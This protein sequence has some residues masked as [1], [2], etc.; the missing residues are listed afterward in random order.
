MSQIAKQR[1]AIKKQISWSLTGQR[2]QKMKSPDLPIQAFQDQY[3]EV[4]H[5]LGPTNIIYG[6]PLIDLPFYRWRSWEMEKTNRKLFI[7]F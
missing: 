4:E 2:R 3:P 5:K 1:V 7:K 6:L